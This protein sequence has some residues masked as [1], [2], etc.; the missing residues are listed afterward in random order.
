[1]LV[2]AWAQENGLVLGQ[3]QVRDKSN[4]IT[5]VPEF[6]RALE[7]AGCI[8]TL[9]AMGCQKNIAKEIKEADAE[10][11][12]ALKCNHEVAHQEVMS[13]LDDAILRAA[14]ELVRHET[15][16]RDRGRLEMRTCWQ[17]ADL[18]WFAD[19][20]KWEGLHR[21]GVVEARRQV[22]NGPVTVERRYYLSSLGLDAA[23]F[24]RAVRGHWSVENQCHW[25]LDVQMG[26]DQSRVRLGHAAQNLGTLRRL[27]ARKKQ[28]ARDQRQTEERR[29]GPQFPPQ[30]SGRRNLSASALA[31]GR[32]HG[33][34]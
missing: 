13:Y 11:V 9:D 21:V 4:E 3:L 10:Y 12:L 19:R 20:E 17:S 18:G 6:L 5:A 34:T 8:V 32:N 22:G 24:A 33:A 2:S 30:T 31:A 1:M 23:R 15:V 27:K 25:L 16:E 29:L 26:E 14:K 28:A 7:L